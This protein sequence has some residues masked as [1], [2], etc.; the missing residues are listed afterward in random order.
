MTEWGEKAEKMGRNI[1][2][3]ELSSPGEVSSSVTFNTFTSVILKPGLYQSI[4]LFPSKSSFQNSNL[5]MIQVLSIL[6]FQSK[7]KIFFP[8]C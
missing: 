4:D 2:S 5:S 6:G 7:K 8:F 1:S 3:R